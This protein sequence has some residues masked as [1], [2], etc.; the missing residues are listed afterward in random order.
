MMTYGYTQICE[1]LT[2][3]LFEKIENN[4][5]KQTAI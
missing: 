3:Y 2:N 1:K 5:L 4:N